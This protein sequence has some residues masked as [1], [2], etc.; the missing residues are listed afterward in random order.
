MKGADKLVGKM[1]DGV[2]SAVKGAEK[3][4]EH[5]IKDASNGMKNATSSGRFIKA[6]LFWRPEKYLKPW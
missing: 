6:D 1:A 2:G 4:V 5:M 3:G